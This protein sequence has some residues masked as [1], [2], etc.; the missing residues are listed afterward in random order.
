MINLTIDLMAKVLGH[1]MLCIEHGQH[2]EAERSLRSVSKSLST[3]LGKNC[4]LSS[5][6]TD[7]DESLQVLSLDFLLVLVDS[8]IVAIEH[9]QQEEAMGLI[10]QAVEALKK[11]AASSDKLMRLNDIVDGVDMDE[12]AD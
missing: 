6:D 12:G 3:F 5:E 2:D 8:T 4:E 10:N 7:F 9:H 1:A 11:K